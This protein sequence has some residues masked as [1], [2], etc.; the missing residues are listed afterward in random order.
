MTCSICLRI[1]MVHLVAHTT[2]RLGEDAYTDT[3]GYRHSSMH[4]I[5]TAM[6]WTL[7]FHLSVHHTGSFTFPAKQQAYIADPLLHLSIEC[8]PPQ[9]H[10][11]WHFRNVNEPDAPTQLE[12][13]VNASAIDTCRSPLFSNC[14]LRRCMIMRL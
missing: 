10:H 12:L 9:I 7:H 11:V 5:S 13:I 4:D 6:M 14:I 2:C 1:Q 3:R 8:S